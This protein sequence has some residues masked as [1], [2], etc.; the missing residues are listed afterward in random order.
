MI[1]ACTPAERAAEA[2]REPDKLACEDRGALRFPMGFAAV[3]ACRAITGRSAAGDFP[4]PF[5][6]AEVAQLLMYTLG[7]IGEGENL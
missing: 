2:R 5:E 3:F 1:W 4:K 6:V 7:R